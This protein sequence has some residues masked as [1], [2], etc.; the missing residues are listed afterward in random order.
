VG[1]DS[2]RDYITVSG[3][4][5]GMKKDGGIIVNWQLHTISKKEEHL[6]AARKL[7]P[8]FE[9]DI[10]AMFT[11]TVKEDPTG[12]WQPGFHMRS[13]LIL[14]LDRETGICETQNTIF[15]LEEEGEDCLP[16]MGAAVLNIFY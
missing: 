12:R 6:E 5:Q 2:G 1:Q 11:G 4:Y 3:D 9:M 8:G 15:K 10:V 14:K 7:N 16:D 13:S